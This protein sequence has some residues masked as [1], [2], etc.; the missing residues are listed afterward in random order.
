MKT[1]PSTPDFFRSRIDAMVDQKHPLFI[2]ASRMPWATLEAALRAA[3]VSKVKT[4]TTELR[5]DLFGCSEQTKPR[6]NANAGRPPLSVRLLAGLLYLKHAYNESDESVCAK[7]AENPYWQY[8]CGEDYFEP[9]QPCDAT[10][11]V[12]FRDWLEAAGAEQLLSS[13]ISTA[14]KIEAIKPK[15]FETIV[16]DSTVQ[17]KAIAFPTDSRLLEVARHKL[18]KIAKS[19]GIA[20]KQ[21][22]AKE[23]KALRWQAGRYA[24]AKQFKRMRKA[25]H[26]QR[27]IIGKLLRAVKAQPE[28]IIVHQVMLERIEKLLNQKIKDKNKLYALH[29]PE[30]ECISKGK[31]RVRYE[32][33]VKASIAITAKSGLV[34]GART[35]TGNPHDSKTLEPQLAQT[36]QLLSAV[37]NAPTPKTVLVDLGYRGVTID[38]VEIHHKAK[39]KQLTKAQRRQ[40][41]RRSSIEPHIGHLKDDNGMRRC[42]LRGEHGDA[43]HTI[44]CAAGHN[45]RFLMRAI[46]LFCVWILGWPTVKPERRKAKNSSLRFGWRWKS[47]GFLKLLNF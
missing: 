25:I 11:L 4:P 40:L 30:A 26:R 17:E 21:T 34:V 20:L 13:T 43:R 44:L 22:F 14:I 45:L 5:D 39:I 36:K 35:F 9:S 2:L 47:V 24:H 6:G 42:W 8:F 19:S 33:G 37:K 1:A 27:T 10:K 23:G 41:K 38:G 32:F 15:E 12:H 16:V 18:V 28:R 3:K 29:A 7:W 46:R 31:A